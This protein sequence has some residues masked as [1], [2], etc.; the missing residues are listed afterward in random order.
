MFIGIFSVQIN[1]DHSQSVHF[2]SMTKLKVSVCNSW[3]RK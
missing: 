3:F 2:D 1:Y